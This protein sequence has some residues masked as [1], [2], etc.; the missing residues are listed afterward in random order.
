MTTIFTNFCFFDD[1]TALGP[2]AMS[3]SMFMFAVFLINSHSSS[4]PC[5]SRLKVSFCYPFE[6]FTFE[7]GAFEEAG[8]IHC[9][10]FYRLN[11]HCS[12]VENFLNF[13]NQ[14]HT[15]SNASIYAVHGCFITLEVLQGQVFVPK[16]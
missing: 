12:F 7:C 2:A 15:L 3:I 10:N 14:S 11:R 13:L 1:F 9:D 8:K 16:S 5:S 4:V 6:I